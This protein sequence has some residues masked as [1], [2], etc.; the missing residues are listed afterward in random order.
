MKYVVAKDLTPFK[1]E[2][3][4][5]ND[6]EKAHFEPVT[7]VY[8]QGEKTVIETDRQQLRVDPEARVMVKS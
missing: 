1:D 3:A 4:V 5:E 7:A 8:T 6:G 2:I